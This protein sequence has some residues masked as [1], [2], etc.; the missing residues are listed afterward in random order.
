MNK[1]L[2]LGFLVNAAMAV[3]TSEVLQNRELDCLEHE[4]ELF[5]CIFV[6]AVTTLDR[7][8]RSN[9]IQLIDSVVFVRDK[10]MERTAKNLK[11]ELDVMNELPKDT[12]DRAFK[13]VSMLFDSAM[14]FMKSHSLKISMPE[15]FSSRALTEARG[16]IKKIILPLI[17][18]VGLKIFALVPILFG[19]LGLL[20]LKAYFVG[21]IALLLAGILFFQKI[22]GSGSMASN[23]F[24]KSPSLGGNWYE[25]S[26]Q[27]WPSAGAGVQQG[28]YR[29]SLDDTTGKIDSHSLAY[30]AYEPITNESQ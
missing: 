27:G 25:P 20:A 2:I 23:I 7:A 6:K 28:Y 13:L 29:R 22:F 1:L 3:P 21:K 4:N 30:S 19:G 12:S 26:T 9:D 16:K 8:A 15:E 17:V 11:T 14:S 10:P 5:S 18:A 24:G